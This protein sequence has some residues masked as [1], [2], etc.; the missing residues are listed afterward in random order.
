M[1]I[2]SFS[3]FWVRRYVV[4]NSELGAGPEIQPQAVTTV[5]PE[6]QLTP[7]LNWE[8]FNEKYVEELLS[9]DKSIVIPSLFELIEVHQAQK[10]N[11]LLNDLSEILANYPYII[12]KQAYQFSAQHLDLL[13]VFYGNLDNNAEPFLIK[14]EFFTEIIIFLSG[15]KKSHEDTERYRLVVF[16][17]N[18]PEDGDG[19]VDFSN[20]SSEQDKFSINLSIPGFAFGSGKS[21]IVTFSE[22]KKGLSRSIQGQVKVKAK[23][24]TYENNYLL[25]RSVVTVGE[26][27]IGVPTQ[28]HTIEI[29]D[30]AKNVDLVDKDHEYF[31]TIDAPENKCEISEIIAKMK[32][33]EFE[34]M[35]SISDDC[36]ASFKQAITIKPPISI[37]ATI[38]ASLE[39]TAKSTTNYR[40]TYNPKIGKDYILSG[41]N[42]NSLRLFV[43]EKKD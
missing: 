19:S 12:T 1:Q 41:A 8:K 18:F 39:F 36:W 10:S 7:T 14:K 17:F 33:K 35:I 15:F 29:L 16:E 5:R 4:S 37:L 32:M 6:N 25:H 13:K 9:L 21:R 3:T 34:Y 43:D 24:N 26:E 42:E 30:I 23:I 11:T 38:N 40:F 22:N 27:N 31:I 28:L 20:S 2:F